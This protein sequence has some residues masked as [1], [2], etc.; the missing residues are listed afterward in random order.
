MAGAAFG[1]R[2]WKF[3]EQEI[4]SNGKSMKKQVIIIL[5]YEKEMV[6]LCVRIYRK[7]CSLRIDREGNW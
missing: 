3:G 1:I 6:G 5:K 7:R 4:W 2:S